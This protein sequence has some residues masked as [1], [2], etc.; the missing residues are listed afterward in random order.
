[1]G[2]R[3]LR[4]V[5]IED[6]CAA[7][8]VSRRTLYRHFDSR[9]EIIAGV[10]LHIRQQFELGLARA[11]QARPGLDDR[12]MVVLEHLTAYPASHEATFRLVATELEFVRDS[13][14]QSFDEYVEM[15]RVAIEPIF[16]ARPELAD[17]ELNDRDFSAL[18]MRF[19]LQALLTPTIPNAQTIETFSTYWRLAV[20]GAS[21]ARQSPLPRRRRRA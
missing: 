7:S 6:I 5:S 12:V 2:R 13:L 10:A 1:M 21:M 19:A 9:E 3:G 16:V 20:Q 11:I 4:K 17:G 8:G 14:I 18:I 15:I